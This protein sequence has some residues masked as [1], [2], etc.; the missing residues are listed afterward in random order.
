MT[1]TDINCK[2]YQTVREVQLPNV[3][4]ALLSLKTIIPLC[5]H[6]IKENKG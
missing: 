1:L 2:L 4:G 6:H 5:L 3:F